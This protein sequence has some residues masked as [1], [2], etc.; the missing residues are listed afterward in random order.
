MNRV[1]TTEPEQLER[2]WEQPG[3]KR[4][5]DYTWEEFLDLSGVLQIAF[6]NDFGADA[7]EEWM[8]RVK[9]QS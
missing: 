5:E 8:N 7:F 4:L 2:P 9:P 3:G 6:Q 1:Q